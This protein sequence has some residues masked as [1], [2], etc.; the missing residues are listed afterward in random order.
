MENNAIL[1]FFCSLHPK[2]QSPEQAS[3]LLLVRIY[4]SSLHST[5]LWLQLKGKS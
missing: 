2:Q 5:V 3:V 4:V 1:I